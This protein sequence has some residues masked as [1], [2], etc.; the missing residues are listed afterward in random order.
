[1]R[2]ALA[3]SRSSRRS[4]RRGRH[5]ARAAGAGT[6]TAALPCRSRAPRRRRQRRDPSSRRALR[7]A[8]RRRPHRVANKAL[9]DPDTVRVRADFAPYASTGQRQVERTENASTV[10]FRY[11]FTLRCLDQECAPETDRKVIELPGAGVFYRF[12]SAQGQ[13][14]AIIDWPAFEVTARV[15]VES[16]APER[17]RA[18]AATLPAVSFSRSPGTA[19]RGSSSRAPRARP[20]R[21]ADLAAAAPGG[22]RGGRRGRGS[23]GARDAARAGAPA[24][25]RGLPRR[26][27]ARAPQGLR[28]GRPRARRPR[29]RRPRRPRAGA[30]MVAG[31]PSAGVV[32]ELEREALAATNG[33]LA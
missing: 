12:R 17:W 1:M 32:D 26:R 31:T 8:G 33:S 30:R 10:R 18:D 27:L 21:V 5:R 3:A 11:R 4:R 28:A 29:P 23:G 13:G 15:P 24:R 19:P 7:R 6:G 20:A 2:R 16:L 9:V 14:T 25:P 22:D